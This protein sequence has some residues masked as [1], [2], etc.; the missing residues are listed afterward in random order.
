MKL[1][2]L[3]SE[4][5]LG[6]VTLPNRVVM[7]AMSSGLA[8]E[9]GRVTDRLIAYYAERARGG[10]GLVIVEF[11]CVDGTFG[12]S[13]RTQLVVDDDAV[14]A[15]HARL[16]EAI[17]SA[18]S[19]AALQLQL[20]GQFSYRVPGQLPVAP[21]DVYSSRDG[22]LR[23]RAL[24]S[25]EIELLVDRFAAA[26][27]RAVAAGY[28]ALEL[29]GAHGY[30]LN[31]FLSPA[32]NRRDD[33]WGGDAERRLAFPVA[34]IR[35]V[36]AELGERPLLY[37]FSAE[38]YIRGGLTID[39]WVHIAPK[40]VAAGVDGLDVSTGSLAG[41]LE[42]AVD[43]MSTEGWRFDLAR[44]IR[45]VV[46]VP[47]VGIGARFPETAERALR[48]GFV[49][50]IGLGRPLLADAAWAAKARAGDD[51]TIRPCTSCNWCFDR[52]L[53]HE[54]ISCAENPRTGREEIPTLPADAGRGRHV[55]VV[56][57]GP[58]GL[59]AAIQARSV[60]F[61]ATLVEREPVL[62]GGLIA[63]AAPPHK[64]NL[65]WYRDY[66]LERVGQSG[67]E[68]RLGQPATLETILALGP[69]AVI[70]ATGATA[71]RLGL[72]GEEHPHVFSAYDLLLGKGPAPAEWRG[73]VVV[74]GGGE[75]G[76]EMAELVA[77]Q[78]LAV[79]LVSRSPES[80]LARAAEAMYRKVLLGR[81]RTNPAVTILTETHIESI[82]VDGVTIRDASGT[83][84][85]PA[86]MVI[87]AQG[88]TSNRPGYAK[89]R[90]RGIRT[91]L[92]GDANQIRRIGEAVHDA[93]AAIADLVGSG[94][95]PPP[96]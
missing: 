7:A 51:R 64:D 21:S 73:P 1:P 19:V 59:A 25:E 52:V 20:P 13:E 69:D 93:N 72:P 48:D 66:L 9:R 70:L 29:H 87:L 58:G 45:Q 86:R 61:R 37:R 95:E 53:K 89:L 80:Q 28:D 92:I 83:R 10:V 5:R 2:H 68:V 56:G 96:A 24:T 40:L 77:A 15:G 23:A 79:T 34:V 76:C 91:Y 41:A 65:T 18:G 50:L 22:S 75:T 11:A 3:F 30:L 71:A 55:V 42:R 31:A 44:R 74:Y 67:V 88:R 46:D 60:G 12:I 62:G 84:V 43:P 82:A 90:D 57:G 38:E 85:V 94:G 36:K 39:D 35:A 32:M 16:V 6:A 17:K 14:I 26:A 33:R 78:G 81:L 49:D 47:V 63:S 54:P 4:L 8:D 27:R